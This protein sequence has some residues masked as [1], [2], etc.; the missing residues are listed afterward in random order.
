MYK[1]TSNGT[2]L[3]VQNEKMWKNSM[4]VMEK[5]LMW[6]QCYLTNMDTLLQVVGVNQTD[7]IFYSQMEHTLEKI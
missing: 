5:E 6:L 1:G 4:A 7:C 3:V 2:I